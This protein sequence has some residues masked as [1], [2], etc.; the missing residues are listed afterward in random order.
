[1]S[2]ITFGRASGNSLS[3]ERNQNLRPQR[4]SVKSERVR[5]RRILK[6]RQNPHLP[7][8]ESW[9]NWQEGKG[10]EFVERIKLEK[11]KRK[12]KVENI[13]LGEVTSCNIHAFWL[14][15]I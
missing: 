12:K 13:E 6:V 14:T 5:P 1:M 11:V 8:G 7:N 9:S 15:Q 2:F 3:I 10:E 4:R